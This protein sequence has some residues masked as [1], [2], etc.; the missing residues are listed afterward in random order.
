MKRSFNYT[1]RKRIKRESVILRLKKIENQP[2]LCDI[3]LRLDGYGLPPDAALYLEV[4]DRFDYKRIALGEVS[5]FQPL[6]REIGEFLSEDALRFRVKAVDE[7]E[8]HGRILAL[9]AGIATK[10]PM[11]PNSLLYFKPYDLA[12]IVYD[13]EH[14]TAEQPILRVNNRLDIDIMDMAKHN[15]M[16]HALVFPAVVKDIL[17]QILF[18]DKIDETE[19]DAWQNDW[20]RFVVRVCQMR[21][22]HVPADLNS[23]G[24]LENEE[25]LSEWIDEAAQAVC[26]HN[27]FLESFERSYKEGIDNDR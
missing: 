25:E 3:D 8:A 13:L 18:I 1:D 22:P 7:K 26:R 12:D 9:V 23:E 16:F 4:F 14:S 27:S 17:R 2:L 6:T 15:A 19:G 5:S 24:Q 20:L 11:P 21:E 10:D